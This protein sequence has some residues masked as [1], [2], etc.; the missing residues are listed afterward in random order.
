MSRADRRRFE[1]EF[2]KIRRT[3]NCTICDKPLAHNSRTFG[4]LTIEGTT[5]L[6]GECCAHRVASVLAS[7]V[8]LARG[9]DALLPLVNSGAKKG[10]T[11]PP[12]AE[13]AILAI[14]SH[15][16]DLDNRTTAMMRQGG[17]Q[18][19]PK[20]ISLANNAWKEDDAAWFKKHPQRS[21]R[22]RPLIEGEA[23]TLPAEITSSIL[24][25]NHQ[26][27]ILVRQIQPG[28]RVRTVFCRNTEVAIPDKEEI[29]HAI[30]DVV[31][32][33]G[34]RGII[35]AREIN[36]RAKQYVTSSMQQLN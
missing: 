10:N 17:I 36:E 27:E 11:N 19:Q 5:V 35:D 8:Y 26:L 23:A 24:P 28:A 6:A 15:F 18:G 2:K 25:P 13:D 31:A 30:F 16:N 3:D 21:H 1:K 7:G 33:A 14:Q 22:L 29:I 34:N 12:R 20:D 32:Q 4:G 9:V